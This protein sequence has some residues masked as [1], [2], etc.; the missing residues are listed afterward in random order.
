MLGTRYQF[1]GGL[2]GMIVEEKAQFY[3][4]K[5]HSEPTDRSYYARI[6]KENLKKA[7]DNDEIQ[8][9]DPCPHTRPQTSWTGPFIP[10]V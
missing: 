7:L 4:L 1:M 3:T 2:T 10:R 5:M 8:R 9:L 6:S